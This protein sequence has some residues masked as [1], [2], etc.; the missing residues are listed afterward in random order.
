MRYQIIED[1]KLLFSRINNQNS[2]Y[3]HEKFIEDWRLSN[4]LKTR[5]S[6]YPIMTNDQN[7]PRKS[8]ICSIS[9]MSNKS[10]T[11]TLSSISGNQEKELNFSK[12][13]DTRSPVKSNENSRKGDLRYE[14]YS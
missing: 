2:I 5:I 10:S 11:Q 7:L 12:Y 6:K 9:N 3:N 4:K 8:S 1:N 13:Y 14:Y